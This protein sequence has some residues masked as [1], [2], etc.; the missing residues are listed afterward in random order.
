[1]AIFK[2]A[3]LAAACVCSLAFAG[4]AAT[5]LDLVQGGTVRVEKVSSEEAEVKTVNVRQQD[6]T[7]E[8]EIM[9]RPTERV[10]SFVAGRVEVEVQDP[11]GASFH[12]VQKRSIKES[13]PQFSK[14]QHAHFWVI[15][16]YQPGPGTLVRVTHIPTDERLDGGAKSK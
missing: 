13:M 14:F 6:G 10:R 1:M 16:P 2:L 11:Q 9:V 4:C 8:I 15:F 12:V 7:M 3:I 5:R